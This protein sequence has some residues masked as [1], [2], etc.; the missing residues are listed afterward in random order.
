LAEEEALLGEQ[1]TRLREDLLAGRKRLEKLQRK[2]T[3]FDGLSTGLA[4]TYGRAR[5]A[6]KKAKKEPLDERL[7][8]L[9]K[10]VKYHWYHIRILESVWSRPLHARR[11]ELKHLSDLLGDDHDLAVFMTVIQNEG[12][13]T[14]PKTR[15]ELSKLIEKRRSQLQAQSFSLAE[16]MFAEPKDDFVR[17][18]GS[19]WKVWRGKEKKKPQRTLHAAA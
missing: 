8:E 1:L 4:R 7:H 3:G 16:R 15:E 14:K 6:L 2:K 17:R 13:S 19:Y 11:Q 10:R 12:L 18:I 5:I 9:R